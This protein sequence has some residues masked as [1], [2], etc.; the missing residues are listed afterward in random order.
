MGAC[1]AVVVVE[2]VGA[3]PAGTAV[4]VNERQESNKQIAMVKAKRAVANEVE[5]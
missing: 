2:K 3:L 5:M 1:L 4:N